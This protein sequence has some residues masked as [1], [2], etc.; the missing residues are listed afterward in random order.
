MLPWAESP[1]V[2]SLRMLGQ[3]LWTNTKYK[4]R[5]SLEEESPDKAYDYYIESLDKP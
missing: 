1:D 5:L 3:S 2:E 4:A